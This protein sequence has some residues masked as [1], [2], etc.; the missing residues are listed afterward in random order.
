[1]IELLP[2]ENTFSTI[3]VDLTH[4]CNM[5]CKNCYIPNRNIP[6]MDISKL[7]NVLQR[8]PKRTFIRLIGA[9]PTMRDDL[10]DIIRMVKKYG[11]KP[12]LVT[13]GL[14]LAH[15][16]YCRDLKKAGLSLIT[17]SMN[18][19]NND[20][21][22]KALDNG[23]YATLKT[24]ALT[25]IFRCGFMINTGTI[26]AKNIN[27]NAICEQVETFIQCAKNASVDFKNFNPWKKVIPVLRFKNIGHLGDYMIGHD[28][29]M[30]ELI[31]LVSQKLNIDPSTIKSNE[32]F[33]GSTHIVLKNI[34]SRKHMYQNNTSNPS[35]MFHYETEIGPIIIRLIDW[36]NNED[37]LIDPD[38]PNR[39]R[40]TQ[41]WKIAPFYEHV[42]YN[43]WGY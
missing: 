42:K 27:E 28:I 9:E 17:M 7:E 21:Y 10:P 23:K 32:I 18:G 36:S 24:R 31:L 37:G 30:D 11:H 38:N 39:G 16:D 19:A 1:M 8:L 6:D 43:E 14:K 34:N 26:I 20:D 13:N 33:S 41:N 25:N 12:C 5:M 29:S 40:L 2:E 35:Y 4:R 3:V 15:I 22:Y